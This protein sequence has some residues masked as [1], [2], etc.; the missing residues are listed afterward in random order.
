LNALKLVVTIVY[1]QKN[2]EIKDEGKKKEINQRGKEREDLDINGQIKGGKETDR[3]RK[4]QRM[5]KRNKI[6]LWDIV[7]EKLIVVNLSKESLHFIG[8]YIHILPHSQEP[9]H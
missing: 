9:R 7:L 3:V 4:E 8:H 6:T 1:S 5:R 2:E